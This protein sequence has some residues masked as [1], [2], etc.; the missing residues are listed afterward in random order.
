M[1]EGSESGLG[2]RVMGGQSP[3][4][5]LLWDWEAEH[6]DFLSWKKGGVCSYGLP[7]RP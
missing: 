2:G 1:N 4:C 3:V 5:P 7:R 6:K